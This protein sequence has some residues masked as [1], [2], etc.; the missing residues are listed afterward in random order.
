MVGTFKE[1]LLLKLGLSIDEGE[2]SLAICKSDV[3]YKLGISIKAGN[4]IP[5]LEGSIYNPSL[6][7]RVDP[8]AA[9]PGG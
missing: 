3:K 1:N 9:Y 8:F 5:W 2:I 4:L 7:L 6:K